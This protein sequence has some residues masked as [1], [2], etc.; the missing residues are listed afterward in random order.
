M[1][2]YDN[3]YRYNVQC[4]LRI[5]ICGFQGFKVTKILMSILCCVFNLPINKIFSQNDSLNMQGHLSKTLVWYHQYHTSDSCSVSQFSKVIL[6]Y[7]IFVIDE[8]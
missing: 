2:A 7:N 6:N 3:I 5:K 8:Q 4:S 1:V